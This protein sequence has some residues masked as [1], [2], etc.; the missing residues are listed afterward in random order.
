[1]T[2]ES[3]KAPSYEINGDHRLASLSATDKARP[4]KNRVTTRVVPDNENREPANANRPPDK[5]DASQR[6]WEMGKGFVG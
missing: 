4:V 1:M 6:E 5:F 3:L 2:P